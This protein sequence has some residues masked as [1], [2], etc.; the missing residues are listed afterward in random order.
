MMRNLSRACVA[1]LALFSAGVVAGCGKKPAV[2]PGGSEPAPAVLVPVRSDYVLFAQL[3]AKAI[4]EGALYTEL[5]QAIEKN[6]VTK[7]WDDGEAGLAKELGFKPTDVNTVTVVIAETPP[8]AEPKMVVIVASNKPVQK[9]VA[10]LSR[11]AGPPDARGFY[12]S[13]QALVHYPDDKTAVMVHPDLAQKYLDGYAKDRSGWPLT[14]E[15]VSAAAGHT[16]FA[17]VDV[18]KLPLKDM[19]PRE[20]QEFGSLLSAKTLT[21]TADLAGKSLKLSGRAGF[22]DAASAEKAATKLREFHTQAVQM[23]DSVT[24][25]GSNAPD[26]LAQPSFKPAVTEVQRGVKE[27]KFE[28]SGSDVVLTG[29]FTMN[30]DLNTL[31]ADAV[32]NMRE[33][34]PRITAQNNLKQMGLALHNHASASA[35]LVPIHSHYNLQAKPGDKPLLSWRVAILPFIDQDELYRQF[36]LDEPWDSEH[37][38]KLIPMMPKTYAS[39]AKPGKPGYTP[40]QMVIGKTALQPPMIRF[41][42]GIPDGT[43]NTIAIV[44]AAEPVVWTKPDDIMFPEKELPKGFRKKFGGEFPGGFHAMMWDGSVRFVKDSVSERT[45]GFALNPADGMVLGTDW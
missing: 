25:A 21:F 23:V 6:G 31:V 44:E 36:K 32:K 15:L 37:N 35:G 41:P 38:K 1:M 11:G 16:A 26:I 20:T 33:T 45:L 42:A 24:K 40:Y 13:G 27:A 2:E 12:K 17:T 39:P 4:R 10:L 43:A 34:A 28:V 22:P 18:Q 29:G 14:S 5:K 8:R 30:V 9:G 19:N 3:N 7:M